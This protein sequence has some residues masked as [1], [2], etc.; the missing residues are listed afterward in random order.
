MTASGVRVGV[1]VGGTFTDLVAWDTAGRMS[2]LKV[3]T[4]PANPAGGVLN[5]LAAVARTVGHC[6][7][8]AHG[9]TLV[10]NAIVE[11]RV[12]AVGLVTTRGFRDVLEI[13]RM[14]R[15]HLYRIDLPAKP[16]PLV[17]RRLRAEVGERVGP[18]GSVLAP[19]DLA[20]MPRMIERFQREGVES[21]AV[22]LLHSYANPAHEQALRLALAPHF[23]YVS[24]S[25][26]I[27]AEFREYERTC[28]TVLNAAVMP[29]A[30]R[31]VDDLVARLDAT[32]GAVP[33]HLLH[34]AG[35]M[36]SVDAAR[37]RPLTMAMSGPAAGVAAAAH[38]ARALALPRALAFDMG[39]TT[40]DVCLI[41]DGVPET[42]RQR[43]LGDYP[44]R[45]PAVAVESIGAGGGSIAW[46]DAAG[47]LK[48]GP[49]S[50]GAV[51]GPACY[52]L[53]GTEPAVSD[54]NLILGYLDPER[55]YGGS[56][57]L[58][59]A[60]AEGALE[61]LRRRFGLSLLDAANAV[62]EVA[63]A[64][65]LRALRLVSVQRG[66]DL[67]EFTLIAYGGAGPGHAGALARQ[68][69]IARIVVPAH[70]GAFSALGCLV[71]PLR[72][73]AVQTHRMRLESW[74]RKIVADRFRAL[75]SQCLA[76]LLDEGHPAERV[77]LRRSAD[78]RYAGQNYELE[79]D[80][81]DGAPEAL[82]STFER[83]HRQL[84]GYATGESVECVN[85]R[86]TAQLVGDDVVLAPPAVTGPVR[87]A[88]ELRAY[89]PEAGE[90]AMPRYE[91][92]ALPADH[93]VTGP[94][95]VED[96]WSTTLVYPG[97]RCR[98]D[99]LGNLIIE[100]DEGSRPS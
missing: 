85:L 69:G 41:A 75:E 37:A 58:D 66:Y 78:L 4:T 44:V 52:G 22:C 74:D 84:Y 27:N 80:G 24:V 51:P 17:P 34:S 3:P 46:V 47:G 2:S 5:G 56:I 11:R 39:G 33:L 57:R 19:L 92:G 67:R 76:P 48:V 18:D 86:V 88:G 16:E 8:L 93:V 49:R 99:R 71:S 14:N 73:D 82:R 21:V 30:A 98:A 64:N 70:S 15:P 81:A 87:A 10:T 50:S 20:E 7:S 63:N 13:G 96:E 26:E 89:F 59:R 43:K 65:M 29:L 31:Y 32:T 61:P 94:A 83:R 38:L 55:I 72:Y 42:A 25:S 6:A 100:V 79:V 68:A 45:L 90:V 53:G 40:T 23:P 77:L 62:V 36:M 95:L 12:G 9:T 1:D 35:G 28:T 60:R 54:A 91:R 97:Q